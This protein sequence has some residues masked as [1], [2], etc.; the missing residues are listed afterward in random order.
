MTEVRVETTEVPQIVVKDPK[1][2]VVFETP[3]GCSSSTLTW[4]NAALKRGLRHSFACQE[5]ETLTH[6]EV[7]KEGI[8]GY[9]RTRR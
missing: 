9:F 2:T 6:V 4:E 1:I 5:N 7:T 8:R 3:E